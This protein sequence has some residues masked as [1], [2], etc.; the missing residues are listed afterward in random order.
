MLQELGCDDSGVQATKLRKSSSVRMHQQQHHQQQQHLPPSSLPCPDQSSFKVWMNTEEEPSERD[1]NAVGDPRLHFTQTV[2]Q[3]RSVGYCRTLRR[4][5]IV[6]SWQ[7]T[8]VASPAA[9]LCACV[10]R[11]TVQMIR[12]LIARSSIYTGCQARSGYLVA[13]GRRLS[14][15]APVW[16]LFRDHSRSTRMADGR[17]SLDGK[18]SR[19]SKR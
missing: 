17:V 10:T 12:L 4:R 5:G 6:K 8:E 18:L 14:T 13:G 15:S 19:R 9:P 1:S 7:M 2:G 3:P 16:G 11:H